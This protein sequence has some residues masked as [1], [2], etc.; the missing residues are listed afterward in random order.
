MKDNVLNSLNAG[1]RSIL[2]SAPE[3]FIMGEDILD[4]YGGAFKVVAG[5]ST[6]FPDRVI[7]TPISE[8][9]FIGLATGAAMRGMRPVVEIMF[10]DFLMLAAD[11]LLNH[12]TKYPWMYND[13]VRV[14]LV[15]RAAMGARRGY[16]PTHSQSIEKH[17]FGMPGLVVV[18]PSPF[19]D[20]GALLKSACVEDHRP[21]LFVE[22]KLMYA[23]RLQ[24]PDADGLVAGMNVRSSGGRYPTVSLSFDDFAEADVTLVAYGGMAEIAVEAATTLMMEQEISAEVLL[25]SSLN[26]LDLEPLVDAVKRSGRLVVAEESTQTAGFGSEVISSVL[27]AAFDRLKAAPVRVSS[28]NLPIAN[29]VTLES[30]ILPQVADIVSA[31]RRIL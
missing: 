12:A 2:E 23:R 14:P 17:F 21:V 22:N 26:P 15:I 6:D 20:P 29:T 24:R 4:P 3:A 13:K 30:E 9:G 1:L 7:P 27:P 11:Q 5:L 31:V 25:P 28:K 19:H 8:A 16:G 10:G 18:A